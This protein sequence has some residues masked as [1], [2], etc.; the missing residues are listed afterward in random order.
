MPGFMPMQ[1][2]PT[3][4]AMQGG[5]DKRLMMAQLLNQQQAPAP[6]G[7]MQGAT[8]PALGI[9][10]AAAQGALGGLMM[11]PQL[12]QQLRALRSPGG[13]PA[14]GGGAPGVPGF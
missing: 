4:G 1:Q 12:M 8:P 11:N 2:P 5:M 3:Q 13:M 7:G 9:S 10:N 14:M 6:V